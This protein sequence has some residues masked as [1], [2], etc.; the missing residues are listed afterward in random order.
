ML[1]TLHISKVDNS[2]HKKLKQLIDYDLLILDE[3]GFKQLPK[4]SADDLFNVISK[5]YEQKSMII[6]TNKKIDDWND[7]LKW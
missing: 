5:R 1:Y 3:L 2:Y 6:T 7:I 4:Y